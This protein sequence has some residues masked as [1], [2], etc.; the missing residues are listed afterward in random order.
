MR[1][2]FMKKLSLAIVAIAGFVSVA[3]AALADGGAKF[4]G[5]ITT[6]GQIRSDFAQYWNQITPENG[7]KW[8]S[9]HSLSNGNSGTSKFAWDNFDKCESAYKWA[10][11]KPGE[12]HF[13]FHAL[14]WG[15][16][17]PNF[18]CK[19]KNP[20][21][22][23]ELTKKYITEWFDA[24]AAKFPDLEYIDAYSGEDTYLANVDWF[25]LA[26]DAMTIAIPE[27]RMGSLSVSRIP[28]SNASIALMVTAPATKEFVVH[29]V[30]A[31]GKFIGSQRGHGEGLAEF[32]R[33]APLAPGMY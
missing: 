7:C 3:N 33:S 30:S 14:V 17:Y 28:Y 21:I 31:D 2:R 11:E 10:K 5:N 13:K 19:K 32:G 4:L 29:L 22:T 27:I 9:I 16:Q 26:S 25:S 24:V 12:R 6:G 20:G 15:S 1:I 23:V 18:L 8:G